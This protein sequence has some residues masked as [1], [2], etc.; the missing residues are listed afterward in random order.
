LTGLLITLVSLFF[1]L[2]CAYLNADIFTLLYKG[3][4]VDGVVTRKWVDSP[5]P[6]KRGWSSNYIGYTFKVEDQVWKGKSSVWG[7]IYSWR[8][9]GD[10]VSVI[11]DP[12]K[13]AINHY[14]SRWGVLVS[15][16]GW[17]IVFVFLGLIGIL[18]LR[19]AVMPP[20][21]Q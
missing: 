9:E 3:E 15:S 14:G 6:D 7:W 12:A 11:Y 4:V 5:P 1:V 19:V 16:I 18:G 2:F 10:E 21:D 13:P 20:E 17:V 8:D